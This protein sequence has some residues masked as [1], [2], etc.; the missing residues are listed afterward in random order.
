MEAYTLFLLKKGEGAVEVDFQHYPNVADK[1]IYLSKGQYIKFLSDDFEVMEIT[2]P[3]ESV[4]QSSEFRVL[5]KHLIALGYIDLNQCEKCKAFIND[6]VLSENLSGILD[7][8]TS[9]WYWQNPFQA[10][11]EEY[12]LIF[13]LKDLIDVSYSERMR[14]DQLYNLLRAQGYQVNRLIKNKLGVTVNGM[15]LH[16]RQLES[17]RLLAFS[18][19]NVQQ[20]AYD[21]GFTHPT[22]FNRF[23]KRNTGLTPMEFRRSIDSGQRDTFVQHIIELL[24]EHH[25]SQH[26]MAFYAGQMRMSV[27]T[28]ASK[29]KDKLSITM[30]QLI[31]YEIMRSARQMLSTTDLP[32]NEVAFQL[33]FEEAAHFTSFFRQHEGQS[34][35]RFR[36]EKVQ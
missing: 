33:G 2:F 36:L 1:A 3:T 18:D 23:F 35:S 29:V 27:Q 10:E 22:Y 5:F 20:V 11:R 15:L 30:G 14:S 31:R 17:K 12:Q 26:Q 24:R 4:F 8:S 21:S 13:D 7:V 28:L 25:K 9:Q 6:A 19:K 16:K 32:I 34:P